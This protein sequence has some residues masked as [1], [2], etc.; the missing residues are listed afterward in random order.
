MSHLHRGVLQYSC[1]SFLIFCNELNKLYHSVSQHV[2]PP[3]TCR[4]GTC[5]ILYKD[6]RKNIIGFEPE[7]GRISK[8][9]T[10]VKFY[11]IT[12]INAYAPTEESVLEDIEK[13]C[14]ELMRTY[15][16]APK[17]DAKVVL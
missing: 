13:F 3:N 12:V 16:A 9:R 10:K 1:I 6:A 5:F 2:F 17:Y 4:S 11:N 15:E 14:S 8:T 7:N